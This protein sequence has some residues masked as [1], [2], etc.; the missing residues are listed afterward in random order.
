MTFIHKTTNNKCSNPVYM[1]ALTIVYIKKKKPVL[2]KVAASAAAHR[3]LYLE[4]SD[5]LTTL[6]FC[7]A[8]N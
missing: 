7:L 2:A 8:N 1:Q 6:C 5:R 4:D 3:H